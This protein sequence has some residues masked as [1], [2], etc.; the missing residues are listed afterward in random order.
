MAVLGATL[1]LAVLS[2]VAAGK[3]VHRSPGV[4]LTASKVTSR[5]LAGELRRHPRLARLLRR[6]VDSKIAAGL[7]LTAASAVV[8]GGLAVFG[9]LLLMVR[10]QTGFAWFDQSAARFGARHATPFSTHVLRLMTQLGG[11]YV[12]LPLAVVV[13]VVEARRQ[14]LGS[15]VGFLALTVGGQYLVVDAIKLM[16]DRARPNLDRLTGFSGPSFPSGHAAAAAASFAAFALVLG[17]NRSLATR[18]LLA[19]TAVGLAVAISCTRVL[20]GVHWLTDVLAGLALGWAWFAMCTI[21]FGG[22]MLRF[23]APVEAAQQ[24]SPPP[25]QP[26]PAPCHRAGDDGRSADG[27]LAG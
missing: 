13:A 26:S 4:D 7:A 19:G 24:T 12:L 14:R 15:L 1:I 2:G 21:A 6:R 9:M 20:L 16:V 5:R 25:A 17:R 11:A 23:A 3:L 10:T 27:R 18:S 22:R 8:V